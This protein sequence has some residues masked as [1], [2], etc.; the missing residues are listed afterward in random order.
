MTMAMAG[1]AVLPRKRGDPVAEHYRLGQ[2]LG[3]NATPGVVTE[4][5][6][7]LSGYT[8]IHDLV[9]KLKAQPSVRP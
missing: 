3:V 2:D 7:L 1:V 5:G 9:A 4:D 8:S 6:R